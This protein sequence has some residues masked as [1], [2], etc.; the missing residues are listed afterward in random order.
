MIKEIK[1]YP[2]LNE[3]HFCNL[4]QEKANEI[5]KD[6]STKDKIQFLRQ[7]ANAGIDSLTNLFR[8]VK[9]DEY[10]GDTSYLLY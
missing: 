9:Y 4:E 8:A 1:D 7:N 5:W 6:F 3:E 10:I 2:V